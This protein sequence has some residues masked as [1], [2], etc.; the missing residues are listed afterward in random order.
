V[1]I[2]IVLK[3]LLAGRPLGQVSTADVDD[4]LRN[5]LGGLLL[6][7]ISRQNVVV[8]PID[9]MRLEAVRLRAE[10]KLDK[11]LR[12]MVDLAELFEANDVSFMLFKGLAN[13]HSLYEHVLERPF[14]DADVLIGAAGESDLVNLLVGLQV[15]RRAAAAA[16]S[17]LERG[18]PVH[19]VDGRSGGLLVD[20]HFTPY[21]ILAP[22]RSPAELAAAMVPTRLPFGGEAL[23]PT[24]E[25]GLLIAATNLVKNGGAVLWT[26]G[27]MARLLAGRAG[28][29]NWPRFVQLAALDGLTDI[30]TQAIHAV[31]EDLDLDLDVRLPKPGKRAWWAPTLGEDPMVSWTARRHWSLLG[32][33]RPKEF[34]VETARGLARWY[35]RPPAV[36]DVLAP[37][38]SGPYP[39]RLAKMQSQRFSKARRRSA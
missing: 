13:A 17:L 18:T 21:G 10:V 39:V 37:E 14:S 20:L 3:H 5:D 6:G 23:V 4:A 15:H 34:A 29:L 16:V 36:V 32:T 35:L 33:H 7:E 28:P 31:V 24:P 27:D 12:E 26:A 22:L 19:E 11:Q 8:E 25:L 1:S 30:A 9:R 2:S 38:L